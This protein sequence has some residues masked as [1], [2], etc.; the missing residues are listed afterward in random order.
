MAMVD[1]LEHGWEANALK[2]RGV[3]VLPHTMRMTRLKLQHLDFLR[4]ALLGRPNRRMTTTTLQG[5]RVELK[6]LTVAKKQM[7]LLLVHPVVH[8]P[9]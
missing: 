6:H 4:V 2:P 7:A 1:V 8:P 5:M 9:E 3:T